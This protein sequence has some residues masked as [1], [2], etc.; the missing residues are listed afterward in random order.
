VG[1]KRTHIFYFIFFGIVA[2]VLLSIA[3]LIRNAITNNKSTREITVTRARESNS[4]TPAKK[5][6]DEVVF[7]D[8][9]FPENFFFGTAY[10]D[11]Q[12]AGLAPKSDWAVR[13]NEYSDILKKD[14]IAKKGLVR[15]PVHPGVANDLFNRYKEE[16]DLAGKY[17]ITQVHRISLEWARVEPEEGKWDFETVKKYKEIFSYMKSKGIEP[18]ICL[19][20]FPNPKWFAD[21]GGWENPKSEYYY[22]KYA[23]FL[24]KELGLALGIK[25]WLTFNEPQFSIIVPYGNGTWPPF[26]GVQNFQDKDGFARM[27]QV[28]SNILDGHRLAYRAIH[29]VL[30]KNQSKDHKIMVSFASAPGSFYPYDEN[31]ALDKLADNAFNLIYSLA[32]D[33]F[34]GNTDRDFIGLNY[35]GRARLKLHVSLGSY[36][37]SWL[38]EERPFAIQWFG[39]ETASQGQR[40]KEF[41]PKGLYELILKF[42]DAGLPIVITEN[43]LSDPD[44]KFREEFLIIHLKAVHDAI[45][46]GIPVIGYQYWSLTDTWEPG[47]ASF[48]QFG[49]IEIDRQNNLQRKLRPSALIYRDII[50]S[51]KI[52]KESLEKHKELLIQ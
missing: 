51:K 24:A 10:S 22:E 25:W 52:S 45:T 27:M 49:F 21:L 48:S 26:K 18:M 12:T 40:P 20:H 15:D 9:I 34:V 4:T 14:S 44:D 28:A 11:F 7:K 41:Y 38:T 36:I 42:K 3:P 16:Y 31:S 33:S 13:W 5:P 17:G 37:L 8:A 50:R 19:N 35:Y 46:A 39:P 43:G 1:I 23:E 30:D 2:W 6:A 29:R 47:D 32:L